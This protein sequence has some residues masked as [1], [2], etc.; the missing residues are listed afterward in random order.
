MGYIQLAK[1]LNSGFN[2]EGVDYFKT[3][4]PTFTGEA[5][6]RNYFMR[7]HVTWSATTYEYTGKVLVYYKPTTIPYVETS[8]TCGDPI[9]FE[10]SDINVTLHAGPAKLFNITDPN[11]V[12][13]WTLYARTMDGS[14][15][16]T[17]YTS[18]SKII[19]GIKTTFSFTFSAATI[20]QKLKE[21]EL[22]NEN[23]FI[24]EFKHTARVTLTDGT[25]A[26]NSNVCSVTIYK[27]TPPP[28]NPPGEVNPP[29]NP[30]DNNQPPVAVLTAPDETT[31]GSTTFV[32]AMGS[33]D[34]EDGENIT[35]QWH[36]WQVFDNSNGPVQSA[37]AT[38]DGTITFPD[39]G[40]YYVHVAVFDTKGKSDWKSKII[41]VKPPKP[42]AEIRTNGQLKEKREITLDGSQ[43]SS[44]QAYPI[45]DSS[46]RWTIEPMSETFA[47]DI[48]TSGSLSGTSSVK[49]MFKKPGGYRVTYSVTNTRGLSDTK[50]IVL[51]IEQDK[52]PIAELV[53]ASKIY[54]DPNNGN[55]AT[56][57]ITDESVSPDGDVINQQ[58]TVAVRDTDNDGL[59]TDE[60]NQTPVTINPAT[61]K[62]SFIAAGVGKYQLMHQVKET[63]DPGVF[64]SY[65][66]AADYLSSNQ[67]T[68][69]IEVDN[70]AP[71]TSLSGGQK[72]KVDV[73]V[74]LGDL[75]SVDRTFFANN[76]NNIKS[77]LAGK[78]IDTDIS[79]HQWDQA[80]EPEFLKDANESL[81]EKEWR[82]GIDQKYF[83]GM[84][85]TLDFSAPAAS[86]GSL[87]LKLIPTSGITNVLDAAA[88]G[89]A[90]YLMYKKPIGS[91]TTDYTYW[92]AKIVNGSVVVNQSTG[93]QYTEANSSSNYNAYPSL[94]KDTL[95]RPY[96]IFTKETNNP[97][98]I[99]R[100]NYFLYAPDFY[101]SAQ[102][103]TYYN[104]YTQ[105]MSRM[106][107]MSQGATIWTAMGLYWIDTWDQQENYFRTS[108]NGWNP[109]SYGSYSSGTVYKYEIGFSDSAG[110]NYWFVR[111]GS[112]HSNNLVL[113]Y[114]GSQKMSLS[115]YSSILHGYTS[116]SKVTIV[117]RLKS[118]DRKAKL[119]TFENGNLL[120]AVDLPGFEADLQVL[121]Y[122]PAT[123]KIFLGGPYN[124]KVIQYD[125]TNKKADW[126]K[127]VPAG[128]R[129]QDVMFDTDNTPIYLF[130]T[131]L[132]TIL[133][134]SKDGDS[135]APA[136]DV[137]RP[138]STHYPMYNADINSTGER[139]WV[140]HVDNM[141][142]SWQVKK[143]DRDG[144]RYVYTF[145]NI[146]TKPHRVI[147]FEDGEA[148]LFYQKATNE[149]YYARESEGFAPKKASITT[150]A[151]YSPYVKIQK[152]RFGRVYLFDLSAY[153]EQGY[154]VYEFIRST[155]GFTFLGKVGQQVVNQTSPGNSSS[156]NRDTY[157]ATNGRLSELTRYCSQVNYTT[158]CYISA[159]DGKRIVGDYNSQNYSS[160]NGYI[161][162]D[163]TGNYAA[164]QNMYRS[165]GGV[166]TYDVFFASNIPSVQ[167]RQN[168]GVQLSTGGRYAELLM[169]GDVPH[170]L[171]NFGYTAKEI[172]KIIA[173]TDASGTYTSYSLQL[174]GYIQNEK[175]GTIGVIGTTGYYY[176]YDTFYANGNY[177]W[178]VF[179]N[180]PDAKPEPEFDRY[181]LASR[182]NGNEAYLFEEGVGSPSQKY[183]YASRFS[184]SN[185]PY[186]VSR[187]LFDPETTT[188][189]RMGWKHFDSWGNSTQAQYFLY[190]G[191][192][193]SY[194]KVLQSTSS[195]NFL[196][197]SY[198]KGSMVSL[199]GN[200]GVINGSSVNISAT[201]YKIR[202]NG[203]TPISTIAA[204]A[205]YAIE[206]NSSVVQ[207]DEGY[208]YVAVCQ[209][210]PGYSSKGCSIY[211]NRSGTFVKSSVGATTQQLYYSNGRLVWA[212]QSRACSIDVTN[213]SGV[214]T[215]AF[216]NNPSFIKM[217]YDKDTGRI[218][219]VHSVY[220]YDARKTTYYVVAVDSAT[221]TVV[222]SSDFL[223]SGDSLY[224]V[225]GN[226][227]YQF[228][229]RTLQ[230][231]NFE[232]NKKT[233]E[234]NIKYSLAMRKGRLLAMEYNGSTV[235][236]VIN[237][238]GTG[239]GNP[240]FANN[241]VSSNIKTVFVGPEILEEPVSGI[242]D[243]TGGT[244]IDNS[245]GGPAILDTLAVYIEN[246]LRQRY[247][248]SSAYYLVGS[249]I[250]FLQQYFDY[251]SDPMYATRF[252][253]LHDPAVFD[254]SLGQFPQ[255]NQYITTA[256]ASFTLPGKYTVEFTAQ[257]NPGVAGYRKW[258]DPPV[259]PFEF[260]I[261]RK[262]VARFTVTTHV[263]PS[264]STKLIT[265]TQD[266][267]Y[268]LD[269]QVTHAAKGIVKRDWKWKKKDDADWTFGPLPSTVEKNQ[270]YLVSL[271]VTDLEGV[272][273]DAYT[274]T[275]VTDPANVVPNTKPIVNVT[276]PSSASSASP[277]IYRTLRPAIDWTFTDADGDTQQQYRV[278]IYNTSNVLVQSSNVQVGSV[279]QW[280]PTADLAD[281]TTYY[282]RVEGFDGIDWS[283]PSAAK[284]L[285]IQLNQPPSAVMT[286]PNGTQ[287][288][289]TV[290][291][292]TTPTFRWNQT[293][294]DAGTTFQAYEL[295][296]TNEANTLTIYQTGTV[297]QNTMSTTKTHV[298]A[299]SLPTGQK[300]RVQ[301]R[302]FDGT[303]WS[304]WSAQTWFMI[305]RA[306]SAD[307]TWSPNPVWEGDGITLTNTSTDA[308]GDSLISAWTIS[309]PGGFTKTYTTP[310]AAVSGADTQNRPGQWNVTLTVT[311][312]YGA[313]GTI[314]KA[315]PVGDLGITG[316]V[317]HTP[318]WESFRQLWNNKFPDKTRSP[319]TFWA[320]EAFVLSATV[321]NTAASTTKPRTVTAVLTA[322]GDSAAMTSGNRIHYN[323][324]MVNTDLPKL[325]SDGSYTMRFTVTWTNG[326]VERHDVAFTIA[327]SIHDVIVTQLRN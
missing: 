225:H 262:P 270:T 33:Y 161:D 129:I 144:E 11:K 268:D 221:R 160:S 132:S 68:K 10:G 86:S 241:V 209:S 239:E 152:D 178:M 256:P 187:L 286:S 165:S 212:E 112:N 44:P 313:S 154:P 213:L 175:M 87:D 42:N 314:T 101:S 300:L 298:A 60:S 92:Y 188:F 264:D 228:N 293:D 278:N 149:L 254:N 73:Y 200:K 216:F 65:I 292:T 211:H 128:I 107:M 24:I 7:V 247:G 89:N 25:T 197:L 226:R 157:S 302:V 282:V 255:H 191:S 317:S 138:V 94:S 93:F 219:A 325:L 238:M 318:E 308:D 47:E 177:D 126:I 305:N 148:I 38:R 8:C 142:N 36:Y 290:F 232:K 127:S 310:N 297:A 39:D 291:A 136:N 130:K 102:F 296:V 72:Y 27:D 18:T 31:A 174:V 163:S 90:I 194:T 257:D 306:P 118:D 201:I 189:A 320:G 32:S 122:I 153:I 104:Q 71:I 91:S 119:L 110:N 284:Y 326:H 289:P 301:V 280:V 186:Y 159:P 82:T 74:S 135:R 61:G 250:S 259:V 327:G 203:V 156:S 29:E 54:R 182:F 133:Y 48:V 266:Q 97:P 12:Q 277:T 120:S 111:S 140:E 64:A 252:R 267:S 227:M 304:A 116:Q 265:K 46:R 108:S 198:H 1:P 294:P 281:K 253:I 217:G 150:A 9:K 26:T 13:K 299:A 288:A 279:K 134:M 121:Q 95:G 34:P 215:C 96:W 100:K 21:A 222:Q 273:S 2:Q 83:V 167:T 123:G 78:L 85:N 316:Q 35:Y 14:Q 105:I 67:F 283:D 117:A 125:L 99:F 205:G 52:P 230:L 114:N 176:G 260:Y 272:E 208:T 58:T 84:T 103:R 4:N 192:T 172:Y 169:I 204:D 276:N 319:D 195:Q 63:F 143:I 231:M 233:P 243:A 246:S 179:T 69:T 199:F 88:Y 202:P 324:Q 171:I 15:D 271:I 196:D 164:I 242:V 307:F 80:A 30:V 76:L 151:T 17:P 155:N 124:D 218:F 131:D 206:T 55:R 220:D 37:H 223:I 147:I 285:R 62:G 183:M 66:T 214:P 6:E 59:F 19:D 210:Q 248:G 16:K 193:N 274:V 309:G 43:S 263:N 235:P 162:R 173:S 98:D 40:R 184:E 137:L 251:E 20:Q 57:D 115:D 166:T 244:F 28:V 311:D 145:N 207:D 237:L 79:I 41:S 180:H 51:E 249:S 50:S 146:G 224:T 70:V 315:I 287:T 229:K 113:E 234:N 53:T 77:I 56:F 323:G 170:I 269:H 236:T 322:T 5:E 168:Y 261:H 312:P 81:L 303:D 258:S 75:L 109:S 49:V 321:T 139:A 185:M 22:K 106:S 141:Q 181:K 158:T 245:I 275:L 45:I 3:Y 190:D 295:R 23:F 240:D